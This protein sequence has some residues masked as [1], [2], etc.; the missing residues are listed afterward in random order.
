[1]NGKS[2][3]NIITNVNGLTI[4]SFE[5]NIKADNLKSKSHQSVIAPISMRNS[6]EDIIIKAERSKSL[7]PTQIVDFE[8]IKRRQLSLMSIGDWNGVAISPENFECNKNGK[9]Y[10][11]NNDRKFNVE[12]ISRSVSFLGKKWWISLI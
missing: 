8:K 11:N 3:D 1:M 5:L 4:E 7:D 2:N 9:W 12:F 6:I 10:S